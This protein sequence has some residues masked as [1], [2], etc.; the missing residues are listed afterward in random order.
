VV[1]YATSSQ[2]EEKEKK[3]EES[4][5]QEMKMAAIVVGN[6]GS[7]GGSG[8]IMDPIFDSTVFPK[9]AGPT[10]VAD[11]V[12]RLIDKKLTKE[13]KE[14][15]ISS[16]RHDAMGVR[17]SL[18]ASTFFSSGSAKLFLPGL[19]ILDKVVT[20]LKSNDLKI[21]VEGHTD[22]EP[23]AKGGEFESN[24]ELASN[25]ATSVV[26]YLVK[27]HKINPNRL[28]AISYADQRPLVPNDNDEN[29][30]KNRRIELLIVTDKD[31]TL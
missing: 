27:V 14:K 29:K 5:K 1:L 17:I 28:A 22:N 20:V 15:T 23:L 21:I 2:N 12:E 10:E 7:E 8:G 3:F 31:L 16:I 6:P 19:Q 25:R 13:E 4:F 11:Y 26:R 18:A 9:K 30:S 24:W